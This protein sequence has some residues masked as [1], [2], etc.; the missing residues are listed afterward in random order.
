MDLILKDARLA[1]APA[2][3]TDIGIANGTI[4]AIGKG[5]EADAE[6]LNLSGKLVSPGL[7]ETHI[8]LDKSAILSRCKAE[9]TS[10][11]PLPRWRSRRSSS[12][13]RTFT[14][15]VKKRLKNA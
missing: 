2:E 5:L 6:T 10:M 11:K 4:S 15:A 3:L 9:A 7:I 8:H 12:P 13:Q 14:S 1:S